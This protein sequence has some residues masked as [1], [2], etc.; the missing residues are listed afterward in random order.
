[1]SCIGSTV[2]VEQLIVCTDLLVYLLH[3][4]LN[5]AGDSVIVRIASLTSLE[6]DIRVLSCTTKYRMLRVESSLSELV[7]LLE[8]Y[9]AS[10]VFDVPCLDLLDLMRC[11]ESV[12]E[13]KE[14]NSS[15]D[16]RKVCNCTKVHNLLR[17]G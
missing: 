16:S 8:V 14:R 17:V 4:I 10:Y 15:L 13:V 5:D 7:D 1:M 3:V 12:E 11:S 2:V 6:E 9:H